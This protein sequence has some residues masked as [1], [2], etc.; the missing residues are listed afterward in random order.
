MDERIAMAT[1]AESKPR[2]APP[3]A[4]PNGQPPDYYGYLFDEH[5]KTPT[6][7]LDALLRAM[8]QYIVSTSIPC[9]RPTALLLRLLLLLLLG[10]PL[11]RPQFIIS[12]PRSRSR[13]LSHVNLCVSASTNTMPCWRFCADRAMRL[14]TSKIAP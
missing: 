10:C 2:P 5:K 11:P 14:A 6:S 12:L 9:Y 7:V 3:P 13:C 4:T 8:A 1:A